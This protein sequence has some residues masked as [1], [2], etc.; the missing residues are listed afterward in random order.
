MGEGMDV[1]TGSEFAAA[2]AAATVGGEQ[3]QTARRRL[4]V[5]EDDR[6]LRAMLARYLGSVGFDVTTA[7][8]PEEAAA[9]LEHRPFDALLTDLGLTGLDRSEGFDVLRRARYRNETLRIVVLTGSPSEEMRDACLREGADLF[10]AKPQPL[11]R[12][13]EALQGIGSA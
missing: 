8:E 1:G 12:V 10:L 5:V 3:P 13:R 6:A 7:G 4:L 2:A 11:G 9:L